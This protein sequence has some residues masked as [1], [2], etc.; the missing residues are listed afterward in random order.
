MMKYLNRYYIAIKERSK[1]EENGHRKSR[2][3][4]ER[5]ED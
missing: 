1:N 4:R 3:I 2:R 5:K